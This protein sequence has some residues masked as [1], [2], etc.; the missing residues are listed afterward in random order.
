MQEILWC[1]FLCHFLC[2]SPREFDFEP[3]TTKRVKG[4]IRL[5]AAEVTIA[6]YPEEKIGKNSKKSL[7]NRGSGTMIDKVSSI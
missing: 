4:K 5:L 6:I 2:K 1:L 3:K 7:T